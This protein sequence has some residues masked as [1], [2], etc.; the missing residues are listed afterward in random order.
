MDFRSVE[1]ENYSVAYDPETVAIDF[2]GSLRLSGV[3]EYAPIV[4]LMDA[5]AD[6]EPEEIILDLRRLEFLNSSGI[7]MLSKF[8]IGIR[9]RQTIG[10]TVRGSNSIPWQSKSL[11]NLQRLMPRLQL[12]LE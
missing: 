6:R 3:Q 9:K 2:K 10:I 7:S 1:G 4:E 5:V 11:K 8:V 12:K